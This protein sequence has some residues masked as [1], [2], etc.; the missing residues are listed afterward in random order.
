MLL[1]APLA[2]RL[3]ESQPND[4]S[5]MVPHYRLALVAM[6]LLIG[7]FATAIASM[8]RYAPA[9]AGAPNQAIA[10]L[11]QHR[12]SRVFNDYDFGGY[13]IWSGIP[14]F[15]DGRTELFGETFMVQHDEA[16]SLTP[17]GILVKLLDAYRVEATLLYRTTPAA[18]LLD[19]TPGWTQIY[20]D[21]RVVVH[22]RDSGRH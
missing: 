14:T 20:A 2:K 1:A 15:I 13:L 7:A 16:S 5:V 18:A 22:L 21:D 17:P 12:V 10:I 19:H 4:T 3:G 6:A 8:H 11:K 9:A